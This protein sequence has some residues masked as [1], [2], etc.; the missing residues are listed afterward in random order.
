MLRAAWR[1][2]PRICLH[3]LLLLLLLLPA[4]LL[5][6]LPALLLELLAQLALTAQIPHPPACR[7]LPALLLRRLRR[8]QAGRLRQEA[9]TGAPSV[10]ALLLPSAP[11]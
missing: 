1:S 5:E 6:L 4:L 7:Q 11:P 3:T 8:R 10:R 9:P 2:G